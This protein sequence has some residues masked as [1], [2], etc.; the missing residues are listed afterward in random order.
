MTA[1]HARQYREYIR[2]VFLQFFNSYRL[3]IDGLLYDESPV[4]V[5]LDG[6]QRT[7]RLAGRHNPPRTETARV[8]TE[9]ISGFA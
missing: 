2:R 8:N 9:I 1:R 5:L 4:G 6:N 7:V 3:N